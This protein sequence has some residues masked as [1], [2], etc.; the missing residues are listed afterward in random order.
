MDVEVRKIKH[1]S[2]SLEVPSDK[3]ISHRAAMLGSL[4][5]YPVLIKNYSIGEDCQNTLTIM[6]QLGAEIKN[7]SQKEFYICSK[8]LVKPDKELYA[9]NS[10][11]TT[12]LLSGILAGQNFTST[13]TGD[14]SLSQRPMK[15]IITPLTQM[16]AII[17]SNDNKLPLKIT[18]GGLNGINYNSPIASAQ[19]KSCI[20][21]AGLFA[22]G[23][24]TVAEPYKSR[25][26]SERM[27]KYLGADITENNNTIS[28]KKSELSAKSIEIAN[29]ISSAAFFMVAAAICPA[30]KLLIKN[31]GINPTRAGI[32][33]VLKKMNVDIEILNEKTICNEPVADISVSYSENIKG[34]IIE[35]EIIPRLIDELPII[36]ILASQATGTTIIKNA[37]ELKNKESDRIKLV[38]DMLKSIGGDITPTDDG[39]IINGKTDLKGDC[40]INPNH[41]HRIAMSAYIG[42]LISQK[43]ILIKEFEW[44]NTSFPEFLELIN[45][46]SEE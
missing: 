4:C 24:T 19:V 8:K 39:F 35:G 13:I 45:T 36:A 2:G 25:D 10:G 38:C 9:G 12:R 22:E 17:T 16:G 43:P 30:S 42:G 34:I 46:V 40:I 26:H 31:V 41:D 18:G 28:I 6:G 33:E 5:S 11:T 29:D 44:V 23:E 15:R 7:I 20:L 32:I 3:S 37:E 1:I 21:F 27:L 14:I